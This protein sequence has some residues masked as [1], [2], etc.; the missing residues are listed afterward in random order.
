[1]WLL[2]STALAGP[3]DVSFALGADVNETPHGLANVEV[4][5]GDWTA[6]LLTDTLQVRWDPSGDRGRAWLAAR[7][8]LGA[9]GLMITPWSEGAPDPEAAM[10]ASYGGLEGGAVRYLSRGLYAGGQG[11][12]RYYVFSPYGGSPATPLDDRPV[13]GGD[14][15]LGWWTPE[16]QAWARVGV[17]VN[18]GT[19]SPHAQVELKSRGLQPLAPRFELRA[20]WAH[21]QDEVL[22]TRV[23]GLNPYVVPLAGAAWGELWVEDYAALRAGGGWHG[24]RVEADLLVDVVSSDLQASAAGFALDTRWKVQR[25]YLDADLGVAPFLERQEGVGAWSAWLVF[26]REWGS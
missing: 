12:A 18:G 4:R 19:W 3:W 15:L 21:D 20:G 10:L 11:S 2:I 17:D 9:A 5:R 6:G 24:E 13:L 1:M 7:G 8:E 25:L 23:G 22:R 14:A 26:G 16:A